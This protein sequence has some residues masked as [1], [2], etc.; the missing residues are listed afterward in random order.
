MHSPEQRYTLVAEIVAVAVEDKVAD[1]E[2]DEETDARSANAHPAKWTI[3]PPKHAE[4]DS[5]L[6]PIQTPPAMMSGHATTTGSQ[7]TSRPTASTLNMPRI[8]A[9]KSTKAQHQNR[10]LQLEIAILSDLPKMQPHSPQPP[11]QLH[12]SSTPEHLTLC[13]TTA[14][15]ST[16]YSNFVNQ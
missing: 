5:T 13:A 1:D 11:L 2:V 6:T 9:A 16:L 7:N 15:D 14:P 4:R 12:G 10:L 8:N 3:T